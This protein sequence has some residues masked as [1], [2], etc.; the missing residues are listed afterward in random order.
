MKKI[1]L[2]KDQKER[3][4]NKGTKIEIDPSKMMTIMK[5]PFERAPEAPSWMS[6]KKAGR[7]LDPVEA[8]EFYSHKY[9]GEYDGMVSDKAF[10]GIPSHN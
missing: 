2:E 4:K 10:E 7:R 9:Q 8:E 1:A 6:K 5:I 3:K